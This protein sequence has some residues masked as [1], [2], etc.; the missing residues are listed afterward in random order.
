MRKC[1]SGMFGNVYEIDTNTGIILNAQSRDVVTRV[2]AYPLKQ[3]VLGGVP[4]THYFATANA[5]A[6][7]MRTHSFCDMLPRC[8][9][10]SDCVEV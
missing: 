8:K 7:Y 5:R 9:V 1:E 6:E 2:W 10:Y 4:E 3:A